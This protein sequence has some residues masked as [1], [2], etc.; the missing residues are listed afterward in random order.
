MLLPILIL[1]NSCDNKK[2]SKDAQ[3]SAGMPNKAGDKNNTK[4]EQVKEKLQKEKLEKEKLE[5]EQLEKKEKLEK[6]KLEKENK[7]KEQ[8]QKNPKIEVPL[9]PSPKDKALAAAIKAFDDI[10]DENKSLHELNNPAKTE[11]ALN[12]AAKFLAE[13]YIPAVCNLVGHNTDQQ[14]SR[15]LSCEDLVADCKKT[16]PPS[17]LKRDGSDPL[18]VKITGGNGKEA[19]ECLKKFNEDAKISE[20]LTCSE[21]EN[22]LKEKSRG[23]YKSPRRAT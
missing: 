7:E 20:S 10:G 6:E 2:G 12:E 22:K 18:T 4:I 17:V 16:F 14:K 9:E 21:E 19:K 5:K 3:E 15:N 13:W 11:I 23:F 8:A 1:S